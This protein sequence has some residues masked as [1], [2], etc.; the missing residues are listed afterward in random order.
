MVGL[1][2]SRSLQGA[3]RA[4]QRFCASIGLKG[5]LASHSLRYSFTK[6]RMSQNLEYTS[7]HR[8]EALAMTSLELGHGDGRGTYVNQVYLRG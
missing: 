4:Y 2:P 5:E 6:E 8:K 3:A 7:G 1:I